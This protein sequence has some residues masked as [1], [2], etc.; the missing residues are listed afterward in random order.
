[1]AACIC[2]RLA[3][4][5][6]LAKHLSLLVGGWR[7]RRRRAVAP[8]FIEISPCGAKTCE[9]CRSVRLR[10]FPIA[11]LLRKD[12][13]KSGARRGKRHREAETTGDARMSLGCDATA[14]LSSSS[15]SP[16]LDASAGEAE[17][18]VKIARAIFF[19]RV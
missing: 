8:Q 14:R 12:M 11:P 7:R 9:S 10:N 17:R 1:M 16:P 15:A 3:R 18:I 4:N 6:H 2:V 5:Y 19:L 13:K